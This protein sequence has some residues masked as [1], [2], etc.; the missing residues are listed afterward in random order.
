MRRRGVGRAARP[1]LVGTMART[2]VVAGTASAV[3]NSGAQRRD[4]QAQT[5]AKAQAFDDAQRQAQIDSAVQQA[6]VAQTPAPAA[7]AAGASV[8]DQLKDL[9]ALKDQGMLDE[10][11]FAAAKAKILAS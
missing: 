1:S 3:V 7:A 9:A 11:E 6:V 5:A 4:A 2:A 8:L 10:A